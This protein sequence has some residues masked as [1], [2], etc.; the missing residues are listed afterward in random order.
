MSERTYY[1]DSYTMSFAATIRDQFAQGEHTAVILDRTYFYPT[2]GG[3]PHDTGMLNG[4]PVV[5]VQVRETDGAILHLVAGPA[6]TAGGEITAVINWPRRF[7]HMQQHTGQHIL[8]QA[9]IQVAAA[10]TV[11]FHLSPATVT[12]DLDQS[13]IGADSIVEAERLANEIVW[14]DRPVVV[15]FVSRDEA[16]TLPLR[17]I[18]PANGEKLRLI[19]VMGFDLTACGGTHV[20]RTGEVGLIKIV[21]KE[22]RGDKTRIEFRC[23]ARALGHY[24]SA[25]DILNDLISLLTTGAGELVTAVANLQESDKGLRRQLKQLQAELTALRASELLAGAQRAGSLR[26]VSAVLPGADPA[27]LRALSSALIA[28]ERVVV[29]LGLDGTK[30]QIVCGRSDDA[31]GAMD[32]LLRETL[33]QFGSRAGGGNATLAQ[34]VLGDLSAAEVEQVL[35]WAIERFLE[36]SG[37]LR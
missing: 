13:E 27:E 17:K 1:T 16:A 29:F 15:R 3:Q 26:I 28:N 30:A 21:K 23:G 36:Q 5:D 18:P 35:G 20:A 12:I 32:Q 22:Q 24:Q 2:S 7:D 33:A 11:G 37:A 25:H 19:E 10:E 8:S 31:P 9:F 14:Q 34:G 6:G 4:R